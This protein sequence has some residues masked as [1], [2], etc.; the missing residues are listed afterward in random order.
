MLKGTVALGS[1]ERINFEKFE[2]SLRP[3]LLNAYFSN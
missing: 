2:H 3:Q 1:L